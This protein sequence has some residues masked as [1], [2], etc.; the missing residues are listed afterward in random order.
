MSIGGT[1][2]KKKLQTAKK[3]FVRNYWFLL[4]ITSYLY[5]VIPE[6]VLICGVC[7]NIEKRLPYSITIVEKIGSLFADHR[8]LIYENNSTDHTPEL[9]HQW[10]RT[11]KRVWAL[12]EHLSEDDIKAQFIHRSSDP[13]LKGAVFPPEAIARAR[14]IVLNEALKDMYAEYTFVIWMDMDFRLEPEYGAFIEVFKNEQEWDAVFAYGIDPENNYWDWYSLRDKV[15]PLGPE[16]LGAEWWRRPKVLQLDITDEWYP[17]YSAFGG[18][19]VYRKEALRNCCYSSFVT[20][21]MACVYEQIMNSTVVS[22]G[23]RQYYETLYCTERVYL[24]EPR[25]SNSE[26]RDPSV[27]IMLDPTPELVWR[28]NS[29]VYKFPVTCEHVALHFSMIAHGFNKLFINPRLKFY[30]SS[31]PY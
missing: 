3:E 4:C 26:I 31:H 28:M 15:D 14:N 6:K 18:C 1:R 7:K 21:D 27:G 8:I 2:F 9:L 13:T 11:N 12:T 29:F 23:V 16:L 25:H 17:V 30:Y 24:P 10:E 5:G 20:S 19:G 22:P